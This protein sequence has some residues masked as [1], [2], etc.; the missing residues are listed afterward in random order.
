MTSIVVG[1]SNP[2]DL[3]TL[4]S[5]VVPPGTSAAEQF[6][7]AAPESRV[8][9]AFNTTFA[10]PLTSGQVAGRPLDVFIAGDDDAAKQAVTDL[11]SSAGLRPLDVGPLRWARELE[12]FRLLGNQ[13]GLGGGDRP[14]H[15]VAVRPPVALADYRN[16]AD[17]SPCGPAG[18]WT[19]ATG[20][21][22]TYADTAGPV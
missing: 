10:W 21:H 12:A 9:K 16:T 8:V 22:A 15:L 18:H 4:D 5:V 20:Q 11:V 7:T 17:W 1:I 19:G 14:R 13:G 2:M 3:T 6:A